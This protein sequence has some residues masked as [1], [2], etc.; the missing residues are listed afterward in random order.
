MF[1]GSSL[2]DTDMYFFVIMFL[3]GIVAC[4][5]VCLYAL[6]WLWTHLSWVV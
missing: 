1:Y 5:G 4:A 6:Y 2:T 3:V